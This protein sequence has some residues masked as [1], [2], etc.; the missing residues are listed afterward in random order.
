M[1]SKQSAI[2]LMI[3]PAVEALGFELWA[4]EYLTQGRHVVL[5]LYIDSANGVGIEDCSEVSRQ[6]SSVLDVEDPI[7][8]DYTLEVSSPGIDRLLVKLEHFEQFKGHKASV[9]LRFPFEGRRRFTGILNGIEGD[10]V[11]IVVDDEEFMLPIDSIDRGRIVP[12][13]ED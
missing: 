9:K 5:R 10:E 3:L 4:L 7:A 12:V 8:A 6:V 1:S 2:E 13:F 11:L